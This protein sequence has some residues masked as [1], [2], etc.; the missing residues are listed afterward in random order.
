[1]KPQDDDD[2]NNNNNNNNNNTKIPLIF[3]FCSSFKSRRC[4]IHAGNSIIAF[5]RLAVLLVFLIVGNFSINWG[6]Q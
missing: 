2:N 4:I 5:V 1:M 6:Y 3:L